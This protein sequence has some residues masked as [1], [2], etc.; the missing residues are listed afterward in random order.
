VEACS[1]PFVA[2]GMEGGRG[3]LQAGMLWKTR[4]MPTVI[5][6]MASVEITLVSIPYLAVVWNLV[7]DF[8]MVLVRLRPFYFRVVST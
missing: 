1:F 8:I 4:R 6:A 7:A 5:G 3:D 2:G